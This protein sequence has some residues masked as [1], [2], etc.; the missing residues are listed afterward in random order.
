[1]LTEAKKVIVAMSGGVDSAVAAVLLQRRGFEVEGL[2]LRLWHAGKEDQ[3]GIAEARAVA[4]QLAI[5]LRVLDARDDFRAQVV[6]AFLESYHAG[7]TPNPCVFCNRIV[8][9]NKLLGYA[10]SVGAN[11]VATGHYARLKRESQDKVELWAARDQ[12]KDQSYMLAQLR[13]T[14]LRRTLLPLGE[15]QKSEVRQIAR[16]MGLPVADRHDSQDLCFVSRQEFPAFLR[17]ELAE[18]NAPGEIRTREGKLLGWHQG[19]VFYTIGQRKG[20][21]AFTEA[22]YVLEKDLLTNTLVVGTAQELGRKLF[23]AVEFNWISGEPPQLPCQAEVKIRYRAAPAACTIAVGENGIYQ[24][25]L[26]EPLRDITPGQAAVFY[27][28]ERVLGGGTIML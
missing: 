10:D 13:Q 19:L 11:W 22:L 7:L 1:M 24:V 23:R 15:L 17:R 20:L 2:T 27:Q 3:D 18:R 6:Q 14:E 12:N 16:E 9:W 25:E 4:R 28:G 26:K 8:K 21:P 5:P